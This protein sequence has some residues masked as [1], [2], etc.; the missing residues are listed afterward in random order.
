M[1]APTVTTDF[2]QALQAHLD[3]IAARDLEAFESHLSLDETLYTVVQ[4]G[5]AFSTRSE[6]IAL[7]EQWFRDPDWVWKGELVHK[8]VGSDMAMALIRYQYQAKPG[9]APFSTWL[10]YVFQLQQ[11][12]WRIVHDQNT[13]MDFPAFARA[14]GIALA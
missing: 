10:V 2:D 13:A 11:G 12:R 5:H 4:N 8:V 9:D 7:H 3:C 1:T 14:A 6:L